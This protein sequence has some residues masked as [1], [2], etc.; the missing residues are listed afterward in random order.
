MTWFKIYTEE[1]IKKGGLL[2]FVL[3]KEKRSAGALINRLKKELKTGAKIL[4]VGTGTGAVGALLIK[5]GFDITGIDI[6]EEMIS[7]A[8]KSFALFGNS[9]QVFIMD[10]LNI[11]DKFGKNS[12]DC[13]ITHGMLEHYSDE[14]INLHLSNQLKVAPLVVCVVP[15]KTMSE[16]YR[17][18]GLGDERYLSTK[19]W[20]KLLSKNF[21]IKNI[22]G[23]GFKETKNKYLSEKIIQKDMLAKLLVSFCA[24][25]EFWIIKKQ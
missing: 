1:I 14:D 12:F 2:P 5:Y 23:F 16:Y 22:Y 8:K 11:V 17:S 15:I 6:D 4:E 21:S 18:R 24:F 19:F 20:K 13:V 25:N 9:N 10:A 7:I 3:N